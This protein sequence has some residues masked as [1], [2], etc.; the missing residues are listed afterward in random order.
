MLFHKTF[1]QTEAGNFMK[2]FTD[3]QGEALQYLLGVYVRS[4]PTVR[5]GM[6]RKAPTPQSLQSLER[7]L[8]LLHLRPPIRQG[9][10]ISVNSRSLMR[11]LYSLWQDFDAFICSDEARKKF[12]AGY[13]DF[14]RTK[15]THR[16]TLEYR[17]NVPDSECRDA[18]LRSFLE[19]GI[20]P[21][22]TRQRIIIGTFQNVSRLQKLSLCPAMQHPNVERYL[23]SYT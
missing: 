5:I 22:F 16:T 13:L 3:R 8:K 19:L 12:L 18:L 23:K 21:A 17:L 9:K 20:Y 1:K 14:C 11:R 2:I 7:N 6:K 10:Y 4:K 15:T